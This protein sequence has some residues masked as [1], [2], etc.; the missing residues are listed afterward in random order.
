[1]Q[2]LL[3]YPKDYLAPLTTRK[4]ERGGSFFVF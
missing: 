4:K 2:R 1:A 3:G